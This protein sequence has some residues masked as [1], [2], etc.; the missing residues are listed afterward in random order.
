L[1][2]KEPFR[3]SGELAKDRGLNWN[4]AHRAEY[5]ILANILD[6]ATHPDPEQRYASSSKMLAALRQNQSTACINPSGESSVEETVNATHTGHKFGSAEQAVLTEQRV[7]WLKSLLQSYPGSPWGNQETRGLDSQFASE[8]YVPSPLEESLLNDIR[9]GR[10]RLVILCGNAG[11]GKTALLQY[12][13]RQLGL[14]RHVA[15]NR[16]LEGRVPNGPRVR[17]NLDG[18]AAW[19]G[20]SADEILD[21][22]L[23]PFQHGPPKEN[24]VHL[25]AVNDGRLLEWI[26]GVEERRGTETPLSAELYEL[27]QRQS[28]EQDSHIRFI[29]LNQRSLVGAITANRSRI[30]TTF[31]ERLIDRLFGGARAGEILSACRACSAKDR[32]RVFEAVQVF[33]PDAIESPVSAEVRN[34]ARRRLFE[35]LQA[36]HLRGEAHITMRELRAALVYVLFGIHFCD[37][38]HNGN[39]ESLPYW[40]RAFAA[41]SPARQGEVLR[42]LARFDPALES[43][44]QIDRYLLSPPALD[45]SCKAP[46][47]EKLAL[48]SARRRA[49][50][51][52]T[53]E[54]LKQVAG[55]Q[56]ALDL[57]RGQHLKLFRELPLAHSRDKLAEITRRLCAGISRLEDLPPQALDRPGVVPLRITPRTPTETAFWVEK[58]LDSFHIETDLPGDGT[59][60]EQLHRQVL[61]VYR[62]RDGREEKLRL[63]AELFHLL[64]ELGD[65]YQLGDIATDDTFAHL[66]IFVERLVREDERELLAWNPT[67]EEQIYEVA[68]TQGEVGNG[69]LQRIELTRFT[70]G[71]ES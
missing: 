60:I 52:W 7:D 26:E 57:A 36:V 13:A 31:L 39:E 51:E 22:F 27:L 49:F 41:E 19:N 50:F 37:D 67:Q 6:K 4:E 21:G 30:D 66:S 28:V 58:P 5:P 47:Y 16:I 64:L 20:K 61:L 11:D 18:A 43:H 25:L 29:N 55:D 63:G 35:A 34:R 14:G 38:Y 65:G 59:G 12:L 40:E 44:P 69:G 42:E 8:T 54:D 15:A 48:D 3:Y 71:A 56:E 33:G 10:V 53:S 46:H 62:Y 17:M 1:C 23:A 32:C 9:N 70:A 45:E 2:E 68:A 24:I